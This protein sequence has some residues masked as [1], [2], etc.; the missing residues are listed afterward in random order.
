METQSGY[1]SRGSAR[2]YY[3][4]AGEGQPVV[5]LHAG[6]ADSRQ[7]NN[8]FKALA[9]SYRVLRYDL[10]GYGKSEPVAGEFSHLADLLALLDHLHFDLPAMAGA[11]G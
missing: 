3:E 10:R 9:G 7:W 5:L 2:L 11:L 8:E 6:V 4:V 1:F